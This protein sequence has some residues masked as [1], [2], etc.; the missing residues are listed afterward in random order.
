MFCVQ[1]RELQ[2]RKEEE[3][4]EAFRKRIIEEERLRLLR[5]HAPNLLG[6]LPK[7]RHAFSTLAAG[8]FVAVP[9]NIL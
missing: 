6:Y 1:E 4:L 2:G 3:E 5:Q 8:I 9:M 7:V